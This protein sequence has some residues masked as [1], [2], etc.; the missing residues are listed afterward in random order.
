MWNFDAIVKWY[1]GALGSG[2]GPRLDEKV[3][4]H[5]TIFY[6]TYIFCITIRKPNFLIRNSDDIWITDYFEGTGHL[7][8]RTFENRTLKCPD[9]RWIRISGV[10][11]SDHYCTIIFSNKFDNLFFFQF[12][13]NSNDQFQLKPYHS[14]ESSRLGQ[15]L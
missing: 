2:L 12:P 1:F 6:V 4:R 3:T 11:Y 10:R 9:F 15:I 8:T 5:L 13:Q 14:P 7:N